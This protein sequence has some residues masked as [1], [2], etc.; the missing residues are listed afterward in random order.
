MAENVSR[1]LLFPK[2]ASHASGPETY[3]RLTLS[4][5]K[6]VECIGSYRHAFSRSH[7]PSLQNLDLQARLSAILSARLFLGKTKCQGK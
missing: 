6:G 1:A 4:E 2:R 5:L 7:F 3:G